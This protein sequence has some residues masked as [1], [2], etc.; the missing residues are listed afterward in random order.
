MIPVIYS[1]A[2]GRLRRWMSDPERTTVEDWA[3]ALVLGKGEAVLYAKD[4][5]DMHALQAEVTKR[6]GL[7]PVDDRFAVVEAGVVVGWIGNACEA[8]G[9]F[10]SVKAE[11]PAAEVLVSDKA[12][13]GW[14]FDGLDFIAPVTVPFVKVSADVVP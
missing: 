2:T 12:S 6:T 3:R 4:S 14:T 10:D 9:D 8:C 7:V 1:A 11:R 13:V 5:L